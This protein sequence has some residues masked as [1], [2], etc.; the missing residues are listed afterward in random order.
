V[1]VNLISDPLNNLELFVTNLG[2][3]GGKK[4]KT[5][6]STNE[7]VLESLKDEHPII[8][9]LLEYREYTKLL[10]TYVE[11]LLVLGTKDKSNRIY[12][13]FLQTGTTTEDLAQK[14]LTCKIYQ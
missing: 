10:S 11:P 2:L 9:K 1:E 8:E 6:Y 3:K 12:T 4:T 13:S 14:I 5:G 7:A